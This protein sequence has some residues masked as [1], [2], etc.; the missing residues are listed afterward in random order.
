MT[1]PREACSRRR[2]LQSAAGGGMAALLPGCSAPARGTPVP[3]GQTTK[4]TVLGLPN[5]RFFPA[6]G[7][8]ALYAEVA[9]AMGR[10]QLMLGLAPNQL[11][12]EMQILAG[13]R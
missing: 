4:A 13:R 3:F 1:E 7:S 10:R 6:F 8:E 12:P 9:A 11:P 2:L 5:E